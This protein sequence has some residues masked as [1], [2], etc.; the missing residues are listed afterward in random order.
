MFPVFGVE[1]EI[2]YRGIAGV[3]L[4]MQY[5]RLG[6][7]TEKT[8]VELENDQFYHDFESHA[9]MTYIAV[10]VLLKIGYLAERQWAALRFG[11]V[12][13]VLFKQDIAWIIDQQENSGIAPPVEIKGTDGRICAGLEYGV[14]FGSNGVF[15]AASYSGSTRNMAESSLNGEALNNVLVFQIGYKRF[16]K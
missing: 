5:Q 7:Y 9:Y 1:G 12:G 8:Q 4:G 15:G 13:A 14:L 3:S 6:Q 11:S 10:P 2:L 16:V